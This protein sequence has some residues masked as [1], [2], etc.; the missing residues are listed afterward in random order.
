MAKRMKRDSKARRFFSA[1]NFQVTESYKKARTS[2]VYSVIKKGC[3]TFVFTS[4]FK[5][6]GKTTTTIGLA[7]GLRRIGWTATF[8]VLWHIQFL[9]LFLKWV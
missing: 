8:V 7:D 3:K 1:L 5:G 4:P 6:E 9:M 2:L